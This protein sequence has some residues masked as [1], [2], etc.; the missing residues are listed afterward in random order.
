MKSIDYTNIAIQISNWLQS[1]SDE[2]AL[3]IDDELVK[4]A[5][6]IVLYLH[7]KNEDE[8]FLMLCALNLLNAAIKTESFKDHLSNDLIK[9]NAAKLVS[10]IDDLKKDDIFYYYNKEELCLYFKLS[11][12]VFSFRHVPLTS[13]ILKAC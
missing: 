4:K 5:I 7:P 2:E 8:V 12:I 10:F 6:N 1:A 3:T 11:D 9:T 13:E